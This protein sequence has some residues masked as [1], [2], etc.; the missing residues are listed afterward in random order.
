MREVLRTSLASEHDC[1]EMRVSPRNPA[2]LQNIHPQYNDQ[3]HVT[4][5]GVDRTYTC[6]VGPGLQEYGAAARCSFV[7]G[8][9]DAPKQVSLEP[10]AAEDAV[11]SATD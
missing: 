3:Y 6:P 4:G 7:E 1:P 10:E 8:D 11:P 5:C 9:P 2:Q